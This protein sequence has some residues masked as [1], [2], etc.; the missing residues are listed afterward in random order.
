TLYVVSILTTN[1]ISRVIA[2]RRI[3]SYLVVSRRAQ[4]AA[5][6]QQGGGDAYHTGGLS[7]C[8]AATITEPHIRGSRHT[9]TAFPRRTHPLLGPRH[10]AANDLQDGSR[11]LSGCLRLRV[12]RAGS[13][14]GQTWFH[15][16]K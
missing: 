13:G 1:T 16:A 9:A 15:R 10:L 12:A 7:A 11:W 5:T 4:F 3:S 2:C 14:L 8:R 6:P